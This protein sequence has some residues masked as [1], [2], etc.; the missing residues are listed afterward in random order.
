[1][2]LMKEA[3]TRIPPVIVKGQRRSESCT[4]T[5]RRAPSRLARSTHNVHSIEQPNLRDD[6]GDEGNG[7]RHG[8]LSTELSRLILDNLAAHREVSSVPHF[9]LLPSRLRLTVSHKNSQSSA[10]LMSKASTIKATRPWCCNLSRPPKREMYEIS[11]ERT[12][13]VSTELMRMGMATERV[14]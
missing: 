7:E 14:T 9:S 2:K 1:M 13:P 11:I 8:E 4:N 3:R 6:D 12:T 10:V 5:Q